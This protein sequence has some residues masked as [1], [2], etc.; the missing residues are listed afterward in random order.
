M[1]LLRPNRVECSFQL[2]QFLHRVREVHFL[3][4]LALGHYG[5][6]ALDHAMRFTGWHPEFFSFH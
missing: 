1:W 6:V 2:W 5:K 4:Q 3:K